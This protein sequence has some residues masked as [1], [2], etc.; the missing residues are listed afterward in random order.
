LTQGKPFLEQLHQPLQPALQE[1]LM[2]SITGCGAAK[3]RHPGLTVTYSPFSAFHP[4]ASI[5]G[6]LGSLS[7][8]IYLTL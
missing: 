6:R 5:G 3:A 4:F 7:D 2:S 8:T 1:H